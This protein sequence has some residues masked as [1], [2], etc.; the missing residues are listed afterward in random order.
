M[1][2][3]GMLYSAAETAVE[4]ADSNGLDEVNLISLELGELAGVVPNVFTEY[5]DYVKEQ[6]PKLKNAHLELK[7]IPGEA[8]CSDCG[9]MYNVMKTEGKCPRCQS[10]DKTIISGRDIRLMSIA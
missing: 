6:F 4:Y 2:E 7:V 8:V 5:F 1:H 3:I 9:S 10:R